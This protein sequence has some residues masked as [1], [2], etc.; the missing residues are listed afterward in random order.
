MHEDYSGS[1]IKNDIAVIEVIGTVKFN[2]YIKPI[3]LPSVTTRSSYATSK[4][5]VLGWGRYQENK[6]QISCHLRQAAIPI[7][8][9]SL[10]QQ[11]Y[12]INNYTIHETNICTLFDDNLPQ[13]ACQGDSGGPLLIKTRGRYEVIGIVSW[14]IG[15]ADKKYPGVYTFVPGYLD[16]IQSHIRRDALC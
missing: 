10:C 14:G 7:I 4:P 16:W 9:N 3:A 15:C 5:I 2:K 1:E 12:A 11:L 6:F 8:E 13:D